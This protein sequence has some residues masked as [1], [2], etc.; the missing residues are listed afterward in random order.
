MKAQLE[1]VE[2]ELGKWR[3]G[4]KVDSEEQVTIDMDASANP[5]QLSKI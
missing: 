1:K 5:T 4:E 2:L 3:A